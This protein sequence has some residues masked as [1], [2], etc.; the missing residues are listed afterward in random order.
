L[1]KQGLD[2]VVVDLT[3]FSSVQRRAVFDHLRTLNESQLGQI[4]I[5]RSR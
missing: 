1:N 2:K 3:G 5:Q 4:T